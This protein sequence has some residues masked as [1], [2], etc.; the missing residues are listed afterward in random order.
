MTPT[1]NIL[2]TY[3]GTT[4]VVLKQV[5]VRAHPSM[6]GADACVTTVTSA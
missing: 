1:A 6:T 2:G 5:D 4:G 3:G